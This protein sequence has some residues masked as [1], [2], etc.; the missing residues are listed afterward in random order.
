MASRLGGLIDKIT[1]AAP[2]ALL[3]VAKIT[4]VGWA[5]SVVNAYNDAIPGLVQSRAAAGRH[6]L[7]ADM[8]AG[9]TSATMLSSDNLHPNGAGYNFMASRWYAVVGPLLPQQ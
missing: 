9:F 8:N 2:N 6:L 1:G 7:V 5:T 3:V 4:P